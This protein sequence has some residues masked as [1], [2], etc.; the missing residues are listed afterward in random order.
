MLHTVDLKTLRAFVTVARAGNVTRAA[1]ELY[2]TQPA[3]T[4]QLKRLARETGLTLFRRTS[5]GLEVTQE[6][7]LL[8]AKAE[9]VLAA[10]TD[11]GQTAGHLA[12]RVRGKL[13]IGTIIDP[14]FTRLGGFLNALIES[15][16]GIETTLR[17]GMSGDVAEGL[18]R[19]ELD[20]G[21]YL[22]DPRDHDPSSDMSAEGAAPLFHA[23]ELAQL[24]YRVV[25]P[26]SLAGFVREADWTQLASLPWIGTPQASV[27]SRLLTRLFTNLGLRQNIVAEVDQEASM[28]AMVRTGIGL[29]LCRESIALHEQQSHG[30]VI[31]ENV[32]ISTK[33]S[34]LCLEARTKD[35]AISA[36]L[37]AIRRVWG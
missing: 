36:A 30:L 14:E 22:G 2:V 19:N 5:T 26:P 24:T 8:A 9:Q 35:P 34:F 18:R 23:R 6:G 17:H 27:H 16:P 7:A 32:R 21:F 13:R 11:F 20:A 3:V 15:G 4:L 29:S 12:T 1:E 33:L 25:A 31:A 37:D 28:V 10:L